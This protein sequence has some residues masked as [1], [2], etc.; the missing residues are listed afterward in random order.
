MLS[1]YIC[2][3]VTVLSAFTSLVFSIQAVRSANNDQ[4][5]TLYATAR[6]IALAIVSL[7]PFFYHSKPFLSAIAIIMIT[8]QAIDSFIGLKIKSLLKTYG[9][10]VTALLN[11]LALMWLLN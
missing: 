10:T 7:I 5:A 9:P 1:F 8:V 11:L 4:T 3:F 2:T 6:S